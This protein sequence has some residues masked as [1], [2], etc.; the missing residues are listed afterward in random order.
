VAPVRKPDFRGGPKEVATDRR[1]LVK[2][3]RG[4]AAGAAADIA[5]A[6]ASEPN[7]A[8]RSGRYELVD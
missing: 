1:G 4:D 5:A 3:A 6:K 8:A 2:R 7:V